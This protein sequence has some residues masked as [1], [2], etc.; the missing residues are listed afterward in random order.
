M[1]YI[2]NPDENY[3]ES[4]PTPLP[5][6]DHVE[7]EV[8]YEEL[9]EPRHKLDKFIVPEAMIQSVSPMAAAAA[10]SQIVALHQIQALMAIQ[11]QQGNLFPQ[12]DDISKSPTPENGSPSAKRM[13]LSPNTSN[14]SD[15]S[16]ASTS[17][18]TSG[19]EGKSPKSSNQLLRRS[20]I[21]STPSEKPPPSSSFS[22]QAIPPPLL[23]FFL[24]WES[25]H[26]I[27][28]DELPL[29]GR[30]SSRLDFHAPPIP[31]G[32]IVARKRLGMDY[33]QSPSVVSSEA[34]AS[35]VA[36]AAAAA[37]A[38]IH[39]QHH[40]HHLTMMIDEKPSI[41]ALYCDDGL[42]S[43]SLTDMISS[44]GYDTSSSALSA[45]ASMCYPTADSYY[46]HAPPPPPPPQQPH[47]FGGADASWLQMQ[48]PPTYHNFGNTVVSANSPLPGHL[49]SYG[50]PTFGKW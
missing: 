40:P 13:R 3:Y 15:E 43:R 45:A 34:S 16:F 17:Q 27:S 14:H 41:S 24:P 42:L 37:T 4:P 35:T 49:L 9:G 31:R 46:Y 38:P 36:V 32:P 11:M 33:H 28:H 44:G 6:W 25:S 23:L 29:P 12:L 19:E 5:T 26:R 50:Q 7:H 21:S 10:P 20:P 22:L 18:A 47:A 8:Y 48:M 39:Q 1:S 30:P 2:Y